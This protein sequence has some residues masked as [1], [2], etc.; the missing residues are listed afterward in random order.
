MKL[1]SRVVW[2]EGMYLAP[3]HF[4]AQARYFE[5]LIQFA[6]ASLWFKPY[7]LIDCQ[8][9]SD[10][11]RNGTLALLHA[12]GVLPDGLA[13]DM[14]QPDR[15]PSPRDI[16]EVFPPTADALTVFLA[17]PQ[18]QE[19]GANCALDSEQSPAARFV[20]TVRTFP[21][22]NTGQDDKQV[23]LGGKNFRLL[24]DVEPCENAVCLPIARVIRD[25]AGRFAFD[26]FFIPPCLRLT[27]SERLMN[28]V[29]G[30]IEMLEEKS[31]S[32]ARKPN[33]T[34]KFQAGMSSTDVA[35][36]W[37]LHTINS[38]LTALRHLYYSKR[39]HPEELFRE[40]S[41]LGGALCT[42]GFEAQPQSLP[43]Y[44]HDHLDQCFSELEAH[45]RRHLD[46]IVPDRT[47][48]I[49]LKPA[50]AYTWEGDI[51]DQ[52]CLDRARW[53]LAVHSSV[54]EADLILRAPSVVKVCSAKFIME[55]VKRALPGLRLTHVPVP[56]SSVSVKLDWQYF[57]IERSGPCWDHIVM[58]RRV[59]VYVPGELPSP[60]LE[61]I[62]ILE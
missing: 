56:P 21:D 16:A 35:T 9:D 17:V 58:T 44:D 29:H 25:G 12:R 26:A 34:G 31:A 7:G 24:F 23:Q 27:A 50:A 51:S 13:F 19:G 52:R 33:G 4:Q 49:A 42:F 37:F 11:L 53:L 57:S 1:L 40:L 18:Q 5:D 28:L 2:S 48:T 22:E 60:Q 10:A 20:G 3:H 15:L 55:L 38:S 62:V 32:L 45:I 36:F 14:P 43:K 59:G 54:P 41:M 8:F 39:G 61:L 46:I 30:L 47:I 6:T